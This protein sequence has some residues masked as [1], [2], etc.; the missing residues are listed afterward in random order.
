MNNG[1][2]NIYVKDTNSGLYI[3]YN[4]YELWHTKTAWIRALDDRAHKVCSNANPFQ[5][6]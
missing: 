6:Q 5:K 2:S 1:D 4:S 3:N